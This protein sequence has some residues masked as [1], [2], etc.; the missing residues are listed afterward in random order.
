MRKTFPFFLLWVIPLC[1]GLWGQTTNRLFWDGG[2]WN[3]IQEIASNPRDE[4][5]I[6]AAYINGV[7]DGRLYFYLK[8]WAEQ[9]AFADSLY[10][11]P[12]DYLT[13]REM[14]RNIDDFYRDPTHVYVPVVSAMFIA[15]M[16]AEQVPVDV[17][18][19]FV[20]RTRFWI[21]QLVLDM[22][23][24]GMYKLLQDKQ[25]KHAAPAGD[26]NP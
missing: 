20:D 5:R 11:D 1:G 21:N 6:K 24:E 18:E 9:Q 17:I 14:I 15:N 3:H 2:N 7:E 25:K 13:P 10:A 23:A 8:T 12:I 22:E 16:Y 19:A 4:Y 26:R